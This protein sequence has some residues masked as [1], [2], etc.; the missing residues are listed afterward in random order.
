MEINGEF[1]ENMVYLE[2]LCRSGAKR[3]ETRVCG[4]AASSYD[5]P[6]NAQLHIFLQFF[7]KKRPV[8]VIIIG[9]GGGSIED[10]WAFNDEQ[11]AY[12]VFAS[13]VPVVSAV[14]HESD[15]TICDFVAD[16]RAPTPSAA[17]ELVT[18][19]LNELKQK[20]CNITKHLSVRLNARLEA[21]RARLTSIKAS[22]HLSS[23]QS[24]I[25]DKRMLLL[26]IRWMVS[27]IF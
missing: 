23:P 9:R 18:P 14:G 22:R 7:A 13:A 6:V 16:K 15:F 3:V 20:F 12:A 8:D 11:L 24:M 26:H 27:P 1:L 21:E 4:C 17:A 2:I 25:D 19:E 5:C 10:L